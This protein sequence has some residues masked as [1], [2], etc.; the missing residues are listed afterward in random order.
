MRRTL[1]DRDGGARRVLSTDD[2]GTTLLDA[3]G[4]VVAEH[5]NDRH[6]ML[7]AEH[8]AEGWRVAEDGYRAP[9]ASGGP[10][11]GAAPAGRDPSSPVATATDGE[12]A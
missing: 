2:I 10:P 4:Q 3:A 5:G 8:L 6:E 7:L 1:L 12:N 11:P 9:D